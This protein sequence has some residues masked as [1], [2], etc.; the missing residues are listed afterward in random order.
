MATQPNASGLRL[1]KIIKL[2]K[3][4]SLTGLSHTE[5]AQAL[6]T[7]KPTISR[8]LATLVQEGFVT[9]LESDRYALSVAMLA[10]AEAHRM[11]MERARQRIQE[12]EQ[13]VGA[14]SRI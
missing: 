7:P 2:L 13:R 11:E 6:A 8:D 5:I 14:A 4:R 1:L 10:I 12:L 9:K 3:G